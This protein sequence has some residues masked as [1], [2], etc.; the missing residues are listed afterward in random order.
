MISNLLKMEDSSLKQ[1]E[2]SVGKGEMARYRACL[3]KG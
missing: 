2:N 1:V 3:G